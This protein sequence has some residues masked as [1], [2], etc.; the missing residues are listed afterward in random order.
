[1]NRSKYIFCTVLAGILWGGISIFL[2]GLYASGIGQLQVMFLRA[3]ISTVCLAVFMAVYDSSLFRIAL[4]DLWVF[5]G[6]GVV[7]LT[8][9]TL[10]YFHSIL[11]LGAS[12][13]VILL[14][15]SPIFVLLISFFLFKEKITKI[16]L[17]ALILTFAGCVLVTGFGGGN[18]ISVTGFLIG[19]CS[20]LGYAL[21]SIFGRIAL[22]KYRQTTLLFYTFL[23]YL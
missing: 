10:C 18:S 16:K 23:F 4:K 2:K 3:L 19:L 1:M 6:S 21:Y 9:F 14:Y 12:I 13:G 20:G 17:L 22:K 8:F 11:V 7:S 15:T 5:L